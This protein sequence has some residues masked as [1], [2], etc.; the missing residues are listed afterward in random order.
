MFA[1]TYLLLLRSD[2]FPEKLLTR[3]AGDG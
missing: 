2:H 1:E 3:D